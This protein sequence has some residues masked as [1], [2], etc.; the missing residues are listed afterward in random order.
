MKDLG[1]KGKDIITGVIGTI[2][3]YTEWLYG[4]NRILLEIPPKDK[5]TKSQHETFD[6]QR[7]E[8]TGK[9]LLNPDFSKAPSLTLGSEVEDTL[10][11]FTGIAVAKTYWLS[12]MVDIMIEPQKL[13]KDGETIDPEAFHINRIKILKDASPPISKSAAKEPKA[14]GGP[15]RQIKQS[16]S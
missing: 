4:C 10:T 8:I 13:N 2:V 5:V 11:K 3:A 16:N 7:V 6:F 9:S 12:G 1:R 14:P 15:Q